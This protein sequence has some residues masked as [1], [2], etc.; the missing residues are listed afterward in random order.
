MR[1]AVDRLRGKGDFIA[2]DVATRLLAVAR[3]AAAGQFALATVA[4]DVNVLPFADDSADVA[5]CVA[6]IAYMPNPVAALPEWRRVLRHDG[7]LAVQ[8]FRA[9]TM[10]VRR[11]QREA[12]EAVGVH[13]TD[14]NAALGGEDRLQSAF[15]EA[16]SDI[17]ALGADTWESE[18]PEPG[19]AWTGWIDGFTRASL[20]EL[21]T[22]GLERVKAEF[23]GRL[24]DAKRRQNARDH[25]S[26]LFVTAR[27]NGD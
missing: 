20:R 21:P 2:V 9:G 6:A 18:L 23:L 25:W 19:P 3:E 1:S 7:L 14:P 22:E 12:S 13:L 15:E 11:I 5:I 17:V 16:G 27:H 26:A 4:A 24:H 10:T 8:T